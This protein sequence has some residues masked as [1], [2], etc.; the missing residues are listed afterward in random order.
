MDQSPSS[1][2]T[3]YY[4]KITC[5]ENWSG[6]EQWYTLYRSSGFLLKIFI[7]LLIDH[8][9]VFKPKEMENEYINSGLKSYT[10]ETL[11]SVCSRNA[12]YQK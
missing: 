3:K 6:V 4:C 7:P 5:S 9:I 2:T 8:R 1:S 10:S 12:T 11:A